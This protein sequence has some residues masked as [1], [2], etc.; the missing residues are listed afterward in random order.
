MRKFLV[1]SAVLATVVAIF[2]WAT[3]PPKHQ[4]LSSP[5]DDGTVEG[6]LHIHSNR[7]DGRATPEE[8]A[9]EAARAGLKFIVITDH[10][11]ATRT[12]EAPVYRD[13]VLC[14]DGTEISTSGGHYIAIDM[15]AAPYPLGGDARDVVEDVRRLGGFGI[16][17]H[18]DSPKPELRWRDWTVPFDAIEIANL[19]TAWRQ[20]VT[21]TPWRPKAGLVVKLLT[22]PFRPQESMASL[23]TRSTVFYRW[24]ALAARRHV[25]TLAGADAHSQI[26]WRAS[27]PVNARLS[28]PVP[29]YETSFRTL[30]VH[31]RTERPLTGNAAVDAAM[32]LRGIRAGHLYSAIGGIAAPPAFEFTAANGLGTVRP[33]DQLAVSGPLTLHVRSDAPDGYLTTIWNGVTAIASDRRE[34]D[35]TVTAPAAPGVFWVEIHPDGALSRMPWL[36]SNAIYV[37]ATDVP[38]SLPVRPAAKTSERLYD[39][40]LPDRWH[41]VSDSASVSA[42]DVVSDLQ[43]EK[44]V[45][46]RFG[47]A[48]GPLASQFAALQANTPKG[49]AAFNRL[50]FDARAER[51]MRISVQLQTETARWERSIY[52]DAYSQP[53]TIFLDEFV[54]IGDTATYRAPLADVRNILFVVDTVNT[55][56]G[57]S[58]RV[59]IWAPKLEG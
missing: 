44:G 19:D 33:G 2:I 14:L 6:V 5:F 17:A 49:I 52:V 21:D 28:V 48:S 29:S 55:K 9:R 7:S 27:D 56:P 34:R 45:R 12:P 1:A 51:P 58:G 3:L 8:I 53:R 10:G 43:G 54:P 25:V 47:L 24:D 42:M 39:V 50:S 40:S 41:A 22:Y 31:V 15:P 23:I 13:G 36:T 35:F 11:D 37:R 38:V 16:A 26:A 46:L 30:S 4:L 20:R 59:W 18:P 57:T 32:V